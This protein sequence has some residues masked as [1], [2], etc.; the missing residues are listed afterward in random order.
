MKKIAFIILLVVSQIFAFEGAIVKN[1]LKAFSR[2]TIKVTMQR[3]GNRGVEALEKLYV[4]YGKNGLNRL[5][6]IEAKYGKEGVN[7]VAKYG[8]EVVKNRRTFNLV[9]KFGDRGFY[10]I[11]RFPNRS[12]EYYNKFGDKFVILSDK[13]GS[14]RMIRYL[15]GAKKYDADGKIMHFLEKFGQKG[16]EFLDRHWGKLLA[17]GFVLL[18]AD[19]IIKSM[20][21]VSND[22]ITTTGKTITDT[23]SNIA[24]NIANSN[25]GILLGIAAILF[26]VFKYGWD[27][28]DRFRNK[29]KKDK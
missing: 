7:L 22:L 21:N 19:D 14:S 10:L 24:K 20:E 17:S 4:K 5:K 2:D 12:V 29:N 3:Y 28:L 15:D 6:S 18:N 16:N 8:D 11:K 9:E 27:F 13:F 25:L 23:T 26:V 1:L